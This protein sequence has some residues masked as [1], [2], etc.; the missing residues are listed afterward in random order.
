MPPLL[1]FHCSFPFVSVS[2][3]FHLPMAYLVNA[4]TSRINLFRLNNK[5]DFGPAISSVGHRRSLGLLNLYR[6]LFKV[7]ITPSVCPR[8]LRICSR[9]ASATAQGRFPLG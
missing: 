1:L 7:P 3:S 6:V 8:S 4:I 2:I 9:T 5:R